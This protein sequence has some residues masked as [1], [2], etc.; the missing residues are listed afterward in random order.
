MQRNAKGNE[1]KLHSVS[2]CV[3]VCVCVCVDVHITANRETKRQ[4]NRER[5][6]VCVCGCAHDRQCQKQT[7]RASG[8]VTPIDLKHESDDA[9]PPEFLPP[10]PFPCVRVPCHCLARPGTDLARL[11]AVDEGPR[12][13]HPLRGQA[14][15]PDR[16]LEDELVRLRDH[17]ARQDQQH[18]ADRP[19]QAPRPH[20]EP[21]PAGLGRVD[22]PDLAALVPRGPHLLQQQHVIV[23]QP[24]EERLQPLVLE[25]VLRPGPVVGDGVRPQEQVEAGHADE[26]RG[27]AGARR[28]R[29]GRLPGHG[30]PGRAR[31][32]PE[33]GDGQD[34]AGPVGERREAPPEEQQQEAEQLAAARRRPLVAAQALAQAEQR[35]D[36][37]AQQH[38]PEQPEAD[39]APDRGPGH[40]PEQPPQPRAAEEPL[41]RPRRARRVARGARVGARGDPPP[42][43]AQQPAAARPRGAGRGGGG[44]LG[45][46]DGRGVEPRGHHERGRGQEPHLHGAP[47]PQWVPYLQGACQRHCT[48][49]QQ[50]RGACGQAAVRIGGALPVARARPQ[51]RAR[52]PATRPLRTLTGLRQPRETQRVVVPQA[53]AVPAQAAAHAP[54]EAFRRDVPEA[55]RRPA[56]AQAAAHLPH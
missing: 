52:R 10:A 25:V 37:R 23:V 51:A 49:A 54:H 8:I 30:V 7:T 5:G 1:Q 21:E 48:G 16:L 41:P 47:H 26:A 6:C 44:G 34:D 2:V 46:E 29:L 33:L 28:G 18:P 19:P 24:L 32:R 45:R 50:L 40:G 12:P 9:F 13:Q 36:R 31:D 14:V 53:T 4:R 27:G 35:R 3:C 15:G 39:A 56:L 55:L 17:V 43:A 22:E 20:E 42:A 38:A 11:V